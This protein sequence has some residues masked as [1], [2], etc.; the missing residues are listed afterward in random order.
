MVNVKNGGKHN[1]TNS[2]V[3]DVYGI[4]VWVVLIGSLVML[5][6][7]GFSEELE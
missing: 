5:T 7:I 1:G 2:F 3:L 4:L 6:G